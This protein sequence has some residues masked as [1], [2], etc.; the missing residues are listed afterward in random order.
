M[1][2]E[3]RDLDFL[4]REMV[5]CSG[6]SEAC[7][8]RGKTARRTVGDLFAHVD[9]GLGVDDNLLLAID[10]DD[11]RRAVRD[12][13]VVDQ[14][15]EIALL[16]RVHD[17]VVVDSEQVAAADAL[18]L[19]LLLATVCDLSPDHLADVLDDH[20]AAWDWPAHQWSASR[21]APPT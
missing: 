11:A 20:L 18:A 14:A 2:A 21:F 10:R 8:R 7:E 15:T 1:T 9:V 13:A 4:V 19:I 12:A 17:Q 3:T 16:G 6:V 5:V